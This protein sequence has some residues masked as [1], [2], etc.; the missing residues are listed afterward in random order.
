MLSADRIPWD[1]DAVGSTKVTLAEVSGELLGCKF[2][3]LCTRRIVLRRIVEPVHNQSAFNGHR[4]G[5]VIVEEDPTSKTSCWCSAGLNDGV[6]GPS[7][8]QFYWMR[9]RFRHLVFFSHERNAVE[10]RPFF[11]S[12]FF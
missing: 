6:G 4:L 5:H 1:P 12:R 9:V 11:R 8:S 7:D 3:P 2:E 10:K